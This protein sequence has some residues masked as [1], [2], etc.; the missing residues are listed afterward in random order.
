[1]NKNTNFLIAV[2]IILMAIVLI[3]P[4]RQPEKNPK[5]VASVSPDTLPGLQTGNAPWIA[6]TDHLKERLSVIGLPA[7]SKEGSIMHIHQHLDIFVDGKP[8]SVP[9]EIGMNERAGFISPV[10]THEPNTIIH[11]ES[12]KVQDFT[13]GQ[14]FDVWGVRLTDQCMGGYCNTGDKTLKVYV[15][16]NPRDIKL[17]D[18]QE[19]TVTYGTS[20]ELPNPIPS[21]YA[22][23]VD[24]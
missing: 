16:G 9:A 3:W 17:E 15:N 4:G 21:T 22:F 19:I 24:L 5:P 7:L 8:V 13:L 12:P 10:H 14:F 18:R 2:A 20:S 23:P 1:M 6:E 11:V